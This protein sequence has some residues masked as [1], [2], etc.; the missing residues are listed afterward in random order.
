MLNAST[1][2]VRRMSNV[3]VWVRGLLKNA[4]HTGTGTVLATLGT[5]GVEAISPEVMKPYLTGIGM[6]FSQMVAVFG[7][8]CGLA[9]LKYVN[10]STA[11]GDTTPPIP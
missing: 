4:V 5:N 8:S 7:V 3:R 11:P 6:S 10:I 2:Y 1:A 9:A